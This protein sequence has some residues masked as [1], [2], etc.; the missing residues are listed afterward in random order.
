MPL[1]KPNSV[2]AVL[3]IFLVL[4]SV[5][6]RQKVAITEN[7]TF[8]DSVSGIRPPDCSKLAK[9]PK[10]DNDVTIFRHDVI[11]KFFW[12]CFVSLV[13]FSY[14]SKFHVNIITGSGIM[15]IFFY[16]GLTRNPE[17]GNTLVW[18]LSNIWRLGRVMNTKF[19][20]NVSNRILLN[21]EKFQGY[22]FYCFWG[23]TNWGGITSP[24]PPRLWLK[25]HFLK[26]MILSIVF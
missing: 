22:S 3:K 25:V 8:A 5:F 1:L 11:V 14:W 17:I 9:N 12:R 13:K 26:Q 19:G 24:P 2:R 23:K 6:V 4:F 7:I 21:A 15:T 18:V 20:A 10:N 16:K